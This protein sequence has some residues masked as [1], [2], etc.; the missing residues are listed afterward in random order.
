[1]DVLRRRIEASPYIGEFMQIGTLTAGPAKKRWTSFLA[2]LAFSLLRTSLSCAQGVTLE[3]EFARI[4]KWFSEEAVSGLAFNSASVLAP[5]VELRPLQLMAAFNLG[6]GNV[7]LDTGQFPEFRLQT[8]REKDIKGGFQSS[9]PFPDLNAQM[10]VGLP[11]RF[12]AAVKLSF[13]STPKQKPS[14]DT[15]AKL[16]TAALGFEARRHFFGGRFPLCSVTGSANYMA[17]ALVFNS[18]SSDEIQEGFDLDSVNSGELAWKIKSL[19]VNALLSDSFGAWMPF[20]GVGYS[21]SQATVRARI[22]NEFQSELLFPTI[23]EHTAAV[24]AGQVRAV[25]G[26]GYQWG[27]WNLYVTGETVASG[28]WAGKNSAFHF[29]LAMPLNLGRQ[30]GAKKLKI[31][32][33]APEA[34]PSG[35]FVIQ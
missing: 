18:K 33:Q 12:D 11:S 9:L 16:H 31:A 28:R 13:L 30:G 21:Y 15:E 22:T 10:R 8:L 2:L 17:G 3:S 26:A 5:P 20:G 4:S 1:M 23:G 32:Q 6:L 24:N 7:P 35:L 14:P 27:A 34:E 25:L 19:G 29:G